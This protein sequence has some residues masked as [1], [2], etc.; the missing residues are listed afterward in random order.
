MALQRSPL[1]AA[2]HYS[3]WKPFESC[4][5]NNHIN[6]IIVYKRNRVHGRIAST[7]IR[8]LLYPIY[9]SKGSSS[10]WS[11]PI[12]ELLLIPPYI[13]LA[14]SQLQQLVHHLEF[15]LNWKNRDLKEWRQTDSRRKYKHKKFIIS[16][17]ACLPPIMWTM[18][19]PI[20]WLK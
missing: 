12:F 6:Y 4:I 16:H 1:I 15:I 3:T 7:W 8:S 13:P 19:R 2:I 11:S 5:L 10:L 20:S 17:A 14:N 18:S 9:Q